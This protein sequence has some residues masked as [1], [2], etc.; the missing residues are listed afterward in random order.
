MR[1]GARSAARADGVR[2]RLPGVAP[3]ASRSRT[4]APRASITSSALPAHNAHE[5]RLF[6]GVTLRMI[7]LRRSRLRRDVQAGPECVGTGRP[8]DNIAALL[9]SGDSPGQSN[10]ARS[11]PSVSASATWPCASLGDL[12]IYPLTLTRTTSLPMG[13]I[14]PDTSTRNPKSDPEMTLD[15][16]RARECSTGNSRSHQR[17]N[18]DKNQTRGRR[19]RTRLLISKPSSA[20]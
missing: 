3:R 17:Q 9:R 1:A 15:P 8:I 12:W 18:P 11:C 5:A 4:A 14:A 13:V 20:Y 10:R 7:H 6:F 16:R 19:A 2:N